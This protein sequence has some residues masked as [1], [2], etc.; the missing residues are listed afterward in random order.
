MWSIILSATTTIESSYLRLLSTHASQFATHK[1][2]FTFDFFM[3]S[4]KKTHKRQSSVHK[5]WEFI[6]LFC[7]WCF[8]WIQKFMLFR[9][10]QNMCFGNNFE[11]SLDTLLRAFLFIFIF[12]L[13]IIVVYAL[14]INIY[15]SFLSFTCKL[16][17]L[18]EFLPSSTI[19]QFFITRKKSTYYVHHMVPV[20]CLFGEKVFQ[21]FII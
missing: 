19:F 16:Q 18:T 17:R 5:S 3:T 14:G 2:S 15:S 11:L 13:F 12:C 9:K 8:C 10:W 6:L 7:C 21:V 1:T 20:H 4:I